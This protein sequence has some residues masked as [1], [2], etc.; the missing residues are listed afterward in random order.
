MHVAAL[1]PLEVWDDDGTPMDVGGS[2][3]RRLLAA[4][5]IAGGDPVS[6][7]SLV[8]AVWG[9]HPPVSA[10]GTIQTYV[11]RLRRLLRGRTGFHEL[12]FD[13]RGYRLRIDPD[14]LD[15]HRFES[16]IAA[17]RSARSCDP[18]AA[19]EAFGQALG[20]W[21]GDPL[22]ELA[23]HLPAAAE[24]A[25]LTE[26]MYLA[27]GSR[28]DAD[29]ALGYHQELIGEL[30]ALVAQHP[31]HE[32]FHC[33]LALALYRANRQADALRT[34]GE[35]TAILR[36]ELGLDATPALASLEA[37]ILNHDPALRYQPIP[38]RQANGEHAETHVPSGERHPMVGRQAELDRLMR[39]F[40][41]AH[42]AAR[43]AVIEG[44]PG[45]GKTRLAEELASRAARAGAIVAWGRAD[46]SGAAPALWPW[47]SVVRAL[48]TEAGRAAAAHLDDL[49]G[50]DA[51]L[52]AG[53]GAAAR[54]RCFDAVADALSESRGPAPTVVLLDDLQWADATSLELLQ[55]LSQ[56]RFVGAFVVAT[57]RALEV[58][59]RDAVTDTLAAIA[60]RD[61]S[62][63]IS[64]Q[65]LEPEQTAELVRS[66]EP[67]LSANAVSHICDRSEGNPF[68]AIELARLVESRVPEARS[69]PATIGDTIVRRLAALRPQTAALMELG[70]AAGRQFD[71]GLIAAAAGI[72][73]DECARELEPALSHRVL[74][75]APDAP[76]ALRFCHALIREVL[77]DGVT[78]LRRAELHRQLADALETGGIGPDNAELLAEHLWQASP[79]VTA[80]RAAEAL[81]AAAEIAI[82]RVAYTDAEGLLRRAAQL[83]RSTGAS[84]EHELAELRTLLRLLE[85]MQATKYFSG[86]D[87]EVLD[88]A[89]ALAERH[90]LD[91]TTRT[92]RWYEWSSYATAADIDRGAPLAQA[93]FDRW[94]DD[95]RPDVRAVARGVAGVAA[96]EQGRISDATALFDA[97]LALRSDG[98]P[99][100]AFDAESRLV[101]RTFSLLNHALHGDRSF[102]EVA[103]GFD[104]MIE[105]APPLALPPICGFAL[106]TSLVL[107]E[108]EHLERYLRLALQAD[109]SR[110]F[111]FWGGQ[112]LMFKGAMSARRGDVEA[113]VSLF[114][115]GRD[116]YRSV[117]AQSGLPSFEAVMG[118]ELATRSHISE[119]SELVTSARTRLRRTNERWNAP[120]VALA[121]AVVFGAQGKR[122]AAAERASHAVESAEAMGAGGMARH[123]R[124]VSRELGIAGAVAAPAEPAPRVGRAQ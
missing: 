26:L 62:V 18:A 92:L 25:R 65:R 20:L 72:P 7:D 118:Q 43:F 34:I 68:Y 6:P 52:A 111:G 119:A 42:G 73:I 54:Y 100:D 70:A 120:V 71:L 53:W 30:T 46:E 109:P 101:V 58:G 44:P 80:D 98:P 116:R 67:D 13:S 57:V 55:F 105:T 76:G 15:I 87:R 93:F 27:L 117:G 50:R 51:R 38:D 96:W 66:V 2:Q 64:V 79:L 40:D 94:A 106:T 28:I 110:Q 114:V 16:L 32:G 124:T 104:E 11:S 5:V 102:P 24:A 122:S 63:R 112:A 75:P 84:S 97:A 10:L 45:I 83:R 82:K 74:V 9:E 59:R 108:W 78:A 37:Q 3:P 23:D 115:E 41:G 33:Q 14:S 35:A 19:S 48:P 69:V 113:G 86:T 29:L 91:D 88:R 22:P 89:V 61:G 49:V 56:R 31:L 47:L 39:S 90:G 107:G 121:E 81:D 99:Q 17:G 77:L 123:A 60:R 8:D 36:N 1:G 85:V 103:A 95:P 4:L 12:S 21:R